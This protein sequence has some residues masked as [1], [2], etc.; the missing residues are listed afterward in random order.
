MK[1]IGSEPALSQPEIQPKFV[2]GSH[3]QLRSQLAVISIQ[4]V[5]AHRQLDLH[6]S[7]VSSDGP[8]QEELGTPHPGAC[9]HQLFLSGKETET[10]QLS[11][12]SPMVT[13]R[14]AAQG[15]RGPRP[16]RAVLYPA[17]T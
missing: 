2:P 8:G 12:G 6:K 11:A 16:C 1:Q 7:E 5:G 17:L 4:M 9:S 13:V 14:P 15:E 10:A 3:E